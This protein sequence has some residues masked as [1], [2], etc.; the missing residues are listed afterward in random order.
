MRIEYITVSNIPIKQHS[1]WSKKKTR[2]RCLNCSVAL[3]SL[4]YQ[5]NDKPKKIGYICKQCKTIF[6]Y[7]KYSKIVAINKIKNNHE[8]L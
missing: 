5:K 3:N 4:T 6:I 7:N 1:K 8:I 2:P